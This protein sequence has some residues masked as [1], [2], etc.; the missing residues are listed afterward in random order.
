M[1]ALACAV[2]AACH[3]D[4]TVVARKVTLN[5][6]AACA[7]DG[8]AYAT[9]YELGD[10]EPSPPLTGHYL[11][12][13]GTA[14]PEIDPRA[15]ALIVQATEAVEASQ[16]EGMW[17][18]VADVPSSGDVNVLILPQLQ[19]C[20]L[21]GVVAGDAGARVGST[22]AAIAPGRVMMVGGTADTVSSQ[23]Y[24]A[25]LDTG[26]VES[27]SPDLTTP[28]THASLTA[29]G[30]G[31]LVAGGVDT[32]GV[33]QKTAEV[34][35]GSLGGFDQRDLPITLSVARSEHGA[36]VLATGETLLVGGVGADGT[37]VLR[38][39]EVI[40]P[41]TQYVRAENVPVLQDARRDPT[42]LLLASGEV[43]VAGGYDQSGAPVST[44]EWF[45][46]DASKPSRTTESLG[47][48]GSAQAFVALQSGGA[49]A[50]V[51][52]PP[53]APAGFQ[54]VWEI[55]ADG[56]PQPALPIE[57]TLTA[58]VFF[59]GAQG[60][61]VLW[62]GDRWL[63]WQP[64]SRS[65]GAL[66]VL[67]AEPASLG[68]STCSPDPGLAMWL[69]PT[70]NA[71]T[72]LRFDTRNAYSTLPGALL[73]TG[74]SEM[75]PDRLALT[76]VVAFDTQAPTGQLDLAWARPSSRTAHTQTSRSR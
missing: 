7:A 34:Y 57:G 72:L 14:L 21:G 66:D 73:V 22:M 52:P 33:V 47:A 38:S 48:V 15:R 70:A 35:V 2:A 75:A 32:S 11:D 44:L 51:A 28:R 46:P 17:A 12:S 24:V 62:T 3:K 61:P 30:D 58:P 36:V 43:L 19:S 45:A 67:D 42:V 49:L 59:G 9:F 40:D 20:P 29:F 8:G 6:P 74:P 23:T 18:G 39:M 13:V 4:P 60:A 64:W 65:F 5:V 50:V 76:G 71:L 63:R 27:V 31:A 16:S 69:D 55:S 10:F 68:D 54:S 37:T 26:S 41:V 1:F 25:N 56:A 53:N